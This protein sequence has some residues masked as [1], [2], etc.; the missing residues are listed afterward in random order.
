[1]KIGR[2][3]GLDGTPIRVWKCLGEEGVSWIKKIFNNIIMTKRIPDEW[4]KSV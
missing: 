1:M 2:D 4:R 3:L